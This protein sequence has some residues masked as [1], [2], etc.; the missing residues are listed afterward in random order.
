MTDSTEVYGFVSWILSFVL[1]G[2]YFIWAFVPEEVLQD[3]GITYYPSKYWALAIPTYACVTLVT[4]IVAYNALNLIATQPLTSPNLLFDKCTRVPT[5]G[6]PPGSIPAARDLPLSEVNRLMF[7]SSEGDVWKFILK[8][9]EEA[10]AQQIAAS[11]QAAG[12]GRA[13]AA[14]LTV[15][16]THSEPCVPAEPHLL[17]GWEDEPPPTGEVDTQSIQS[18]SGIR[19]RI[20]R[21]TLSSKHTEEEELAHEGQPVTRGR[22]W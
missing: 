22:V 20:V 21:A 2:M 11:T 3:M 4:V 8:P 1:Y 5:E 17:D 9:L 6:D 19:R 7:S 18:D 13:A 14:G 12:G 15:S 10:I 16:P